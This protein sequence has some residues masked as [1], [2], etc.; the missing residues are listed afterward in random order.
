MGAIM[1]S[2]YRRVEEYK[3]KS[4]RF[5]GGSGLFFGASR[6]SAGSGSAIW[7]GLCSFRL[8]FRLLL[9]CVFCNK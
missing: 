4:K 6:S 1:V 2:T 9:A 8:T 5:I 3:S 7:R